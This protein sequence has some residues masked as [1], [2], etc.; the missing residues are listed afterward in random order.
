MSAQTP[1]PAA[2][3]ASRFGRVKLPRNFGPL[4]LLL[5]SAIGIGAVFWGAFIAEPQIHVTLFDTGTEDAALETLRADGVI[6]FAEQNIYVVG[7]EDGRLR[8]IDGRVEKTGC[9]VEFL[10]NDPRGVA[11]NP[12]GRTGVL[13]DRCSGA[14]WS[15][16][17]DAIART[18]EPLRTPVISFQVDDA[19]VRHLMVEVITVGGD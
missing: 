12:F 15:I 18:Q 13:E 3:G 5:V 11:R 10:P 1:A 19:G 7:L 2:P 17:G 14:V 8:A 4:M 16:A 9:K 6:A